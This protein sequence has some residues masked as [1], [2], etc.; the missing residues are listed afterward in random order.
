METKTKICSCC[1][2][3]L[4]IE[5]FKNDGFGHVR[6][7][8]SECMGKKIAEGHR[9]KKKLRDFESEMQRAKNAR[10]EDFTPRE[11]MKR[12]KDLGYTGKLT[13][14]RTETIDLSNF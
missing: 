2:R 7:I 14:V 10:L 6:S 4:P 12:L 9:N 1:N 11:L 13:Y 3:E 5:N 8:C